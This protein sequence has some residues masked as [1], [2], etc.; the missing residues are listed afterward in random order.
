MTDPDKVSSWGFSQPCVLR[1]DSGSPS[2]SLPP[3]LSVSLHRE[4]A[5]SSRL[6]LS[7][8]RTSRSHC[9][10]PHMQTCCC[11]L[12]RAVHAVAASPAAHFKAH[13]TQC[14]IIELD[15]MSSV[16]TWGSRLNDTNCFVRPCHDPT[17]ISQP[18]M[19]INSTGWCQKGPS[20]DGKRTLRHSPGTPLRP[21]K[22]QIGL[23]IL[24]VT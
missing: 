8:G 11:V 5:C 23:Q 14:R 2:L 24:A 4:D 22:L 10:I 19:Q 9:M 3:A 7:S 15:G 13:Q 16:A 1:N 6:Y 17:S 12:I 20:S 18:H 21:F